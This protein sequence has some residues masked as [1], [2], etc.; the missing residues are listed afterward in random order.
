VISRDRGADYA[1]AATQ[2][3]PQAVQV[4]DRWHII[5]NLSETLALVLEHYRVQLRSVSQFLVPPPRPEPEKEH[6]Q[7]LPLLYRRLLD[8]PIELLSSN[9]CSAFA[10]RIASSG[11]KR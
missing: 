9:R 10:E 4:A 7:E 6:K 5:H 8:I 11:I 1:T 3:A 2:G